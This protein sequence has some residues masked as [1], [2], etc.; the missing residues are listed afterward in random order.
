MV[1]DEGKQGSDYKYSQPTACF[2]LHKLVCTVPC[3][4]CLQ[5]S[6]ASLG[7]RDHLIVKRGGGKRFQPEA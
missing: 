7:L 5:F 2:T 6:I 4:T 3:F 1:P